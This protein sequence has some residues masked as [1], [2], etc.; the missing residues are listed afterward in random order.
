GWE[1]RAR[2]T[3]SQ[4]ERH[5][6]EG[7]DSAQSIGA[8]LLTGTRDLSDVRDRRR[9]LDPDRKAC[10]LTDGHGDGS[11]RPGII[12]EEHPA[13]TNI[14]ARDVDLQTRHA[15]HTIHARR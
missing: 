10:A 2:L 1:G 9:Q 15:G 8:G 14:G 6:D 5:A 12:A 7:V 4:V 11:R 13:L 3:A